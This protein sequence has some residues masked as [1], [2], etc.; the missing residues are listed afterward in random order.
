VNK[1]NKDRLLLI[2]TKNPVAGKVKTR[3]AK[4]LGDEKALEIYQFLLE[5]S[6]K[7]TSEVDADRM[8][9]YSDSVNENDIWSADNFQKSKQFGDDLGQRMFNAFMDG[10]KEGYQK[11]VIIGSDM[12]DIETKDIELAFSELEKHDYVIGPALDGGY[13]LFG[14]KSL[15]SDV[16]KNKE[17]GTSSVR[18]DTLNDLEGEDV[19]LLE[20]KN[21]VDLLDDIKDHPAFQKFINI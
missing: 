13:Y 8:V 7:F 20:I 16:F 4:D 15:N 3:L 12:Y 17:W 9:Y 19:K 10:F 2:F 1:E 5:H 6:V 21:D 18:K 14:M 11:I